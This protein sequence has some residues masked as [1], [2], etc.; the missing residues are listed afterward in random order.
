MEGPVR[1]TATFPGS[2]SN[3]KQSPPGY[4]PQ[5]PAESPEDREPIR[6]Y[7]P[8][9]TDKPPGYFPRP[10]EVDREYGF[11]PRKPANTE[12]IV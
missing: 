3:L 6:G 1:S 9:P 11:D 5:P 12:K 10:V 4:F 2:I 8:K 7:F